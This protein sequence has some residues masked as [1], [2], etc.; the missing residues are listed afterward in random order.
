MEK[1]NVEDPSTDLSVKE[2]MNIINECLINI[3]TAISDL[4]QL[5]NRVAIQEYVLKN[6][7][8]PKANKR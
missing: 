8:I 7:K 5:E 6:S 3:D 1:L 2:Y 4:E